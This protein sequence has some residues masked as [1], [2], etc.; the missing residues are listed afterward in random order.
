MNFTF[1]QILTRDNTIIVDI[2][3]LDYI[4]NIPVDIFIKEYKISNF[5][6]GRFFIKRLIN[7]IFKHQL[8]QQIRWDKNFWNKIKVSKFKTE[9][10]KQDFNNVQLNI[11]SKTTIDRYLDIKKYQKLITQNC[12]IGSPLYISGDC[13]K[14][15]GA[16]VPSNNIFIMDGSRRLIANIMNNKNPNILLIELK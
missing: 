3:L 10:N 14:F 7:K 15:L 9:I 1:K 2:T 4:T 8:N 12:K 6:K 16:N 11:K 13:M 5:W